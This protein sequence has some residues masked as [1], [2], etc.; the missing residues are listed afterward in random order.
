MTAH[1][2]TVVAIVC[3]AD[4]THEDALLNTWDANSNRRGS[5]QV[6]RGGNR[7]ASNAVA[8]GNLMAQAAGQYNAMAGWEEGGRDRRPTVRREKLA[9]KRAASRHIAVAIISG[10]ASARASSGSGA[11]DVSVRQEPMAE[12]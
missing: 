6:V 7:A 3:A 4:L 2:L 8:H 11:D 10:L 9:L 5:D 12:A 1:P